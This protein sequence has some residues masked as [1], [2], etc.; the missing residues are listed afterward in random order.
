MIFGS[1]SQ[2]LPWKW[3]LSKLSPVILKV[4][5]FGE[6]KTKQKQGELDT[7]GISGDPF[8]RKKYFRYLTLL[9]RWPCLDQ[10]QNL[11]ITIITNIKLINIQLLVSEILYGTESGTDTR[12]DRRTDGRANWMIGKLL[13][14]PKMSADFLKVQIERSFRN[15]NSSDLDVTFILFGLVSKSSFTCR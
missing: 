6:K 5:F 15:K 2:V 10:F 1:Y 7:N 12:T 13:A 11:L 14:I 4:K 3:W 8:T 9:W